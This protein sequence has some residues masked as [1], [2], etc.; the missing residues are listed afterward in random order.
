MVGGVRLQA[1]RPPM[2]LDTPRA[3]SVAPRSDRISCSCPD[4]PTG[5]IDTDDVTDGERARSDDKSGRGHY[6]SGALA[7]T[8][9]V[10]SERVCGERVLSRTERIGE[11]EQKQ[12]PRRPNRDDRWA[13]GSF[14]DARPLVFLQ[15][16]QPEIELRPG[17]SSATRSPKR[18]RRILRELVSR[19]KFARA[20]R[21]TRCTSGRRMVWCSAPSL[22]PGS[23][24]G[25]V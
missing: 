11:A 3:A 4:A 22:P 10:A 14:L 20:I 17:A 13:P 2:R 24:P 6:D 16:V 15:T 7:T 21:E 9:L 8:T 23:A 12:P 1:C 18:S 19:N 5:T 25:R